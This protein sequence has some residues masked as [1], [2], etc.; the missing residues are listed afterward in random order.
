[1][2]MFSYKTTLVTDVLSKSGTEVV[3]KL[4][5]IYSLVH[6]I[7]IDVCDID[8]NPSKEV[9]FHLLWLQSG[10]RLRGV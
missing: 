9:R 8:T 5:K 2:S 10:Q 4:P 7:G 1:M 3:L 6:V